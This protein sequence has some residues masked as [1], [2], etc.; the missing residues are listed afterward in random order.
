LSSAAWRRGTRCTHADCVEVAFLSAHVA[1]R[2]SKDE[3]AGVLLFTPAEWKAFL[4]GVRH[5][6]FDLGRS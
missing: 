3:Q 5:G 2:N 4:A 6:D 1:V